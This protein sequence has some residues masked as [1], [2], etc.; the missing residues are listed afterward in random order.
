MPLARV[1]GSPF[2]FALWVVLASAISMAQA[3]ESKAAASQETLVANIA[4]E[5]DS[6]GPEKFIG[7]A[8]ALCEAHPGQSAAM[9]LERG[10]LSLMTRGWLVEHAVRSL[11]VQYFIWNA[12]NVGRLAMDAFLRAAERGVKVRVLVDD[13]LLESSSDPLRVLDATPGI[14]IKVYNPLASTGI[15]WWR[16]WW[17]VLTQFRG[18][19][20]RMHNKVVIA[21]D[22]VAVTGGRNLADEYYDFHHEFNF[23]D[24]DVLVMGDLIRPMLSAFEVYWNSPL[25]VRYH[26][27]VPP[28][29]TE[30]RKSVE[31]G[32]R[33]YALDT[34][35]F[36]PAIRAAMLNLH[37]TF[38]EVFR[39]WTWAP[40]RF[41]TDAPGKNPGKSGWLGLRG[42]GETTRFLAGLIDSAKSA[43]TLQTPYL[44]PDDTTLG[45]LRR[46]VAQG[47]AVRV[48][49]NSLANN[50]NVQAMS[51][52]L[53]R[54]QAILAAG[55]EVFEYK[56]HPADEKTLID[57][58]AEFKGKP[59]IFVL[60][61]KT[62]V[63]DHR[64]VFVGTFNL[65]PRSMNL[66]T[67][68]G[69]LIE[70]AG[71]AQ[72]VEAAIERDMLPENSWQA[73]RE[74]GDKWVTLWVRVKT[75]L[76]GLLPI[77]ALV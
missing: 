32:I 13:F 4:P 38:P 14:E 46:K 41:V 51:G 75:W 52:Y 29:T 62:A 59:P 45:L 28:L 22:F 61:A 76:W 71:L 16:R 68:S 12:D 15:S 77:S 55:I 8:K 35:N 64:W 73:S 37:Q 30:K 53:R 56:P 21:D 11:D 10:E 31:Q 74:T 57:R 47:V 20:Q 43:V 1:I 72:E 50:D 33:A 40:M 27:L 34:L 36:T 69:I 7:L 66:N 19:N 2:R 49:T 9:T 17:N 60:H 54:R 18:V 24:R 23:R 39:H 63:F 25:S 44:V 26:R 67:E 48:S 70:D 6:P 5:A 42:G 3:G 65:D 58:H